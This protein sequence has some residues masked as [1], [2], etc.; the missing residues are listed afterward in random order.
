MPLQ[1]RVTPTGDIVASDARGTLMGNRGIL[2]DPGTR[3]LRKARWTHQ[4]WVCCRL[5]F[6]GKRRTIMGTGTYTELFFLDEATALAAGHRP[7]RT[8]RPAR[9]DEF[10]SAW[11]AGNPVAH[12]GFVHIK[13]I[14]R[15]LHRERVTRQ[16]RQVRFEA[17]LGCL[18]QG[19]MVLLHSR[20]H[21]VCDDHLMPWSDHGYGTS[22][23]RHQ[24]RVTVL[25]PRSIV[26]ALREGYR[27]AVHRA[28]R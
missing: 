23:K 6:R 16:R 10:K 9:Y 18:P 5:E 12:G 4:A 2:H 8:C 7:C 15:Q 27:P 28:S 11:L 19:V 25:T 21:L 3:T 17:P 22:V 24:G 26:A 13:S 14:D 1:N 20:P